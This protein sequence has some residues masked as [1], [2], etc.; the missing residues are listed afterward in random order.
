MKKVDGYQSK[1]GKI[2]N[3]KEEAFEQN[4]KLD[5]IKLYGY[6]N[7]EEFEKNYLL[8][9]YIRGIISVAQSPSYLNNILEIQE[10]NLGLMEEVE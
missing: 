10:E 8:N 7:E 9:G 4:V 3:T 2:F 5:V 6:K 1:D